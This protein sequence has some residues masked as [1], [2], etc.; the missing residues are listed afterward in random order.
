M[1]DII[2]LITGLKRLHRALFSLLAF[3]KHL[4][5]ISPSLISKGAATILQSIL[6]VI[7]VLLLSV[8]ST[9]TTPKAEAISTKIDTK[10]QLVFSTK[11]QNPVQI[12]PTIGTFDTDILVP[13]KKSQAIKAARD[14]EIEKARV[15]A[16]KQ[17]QIAEQAKAQPVA[18]KPVL[19]PS[20]GSVWDHLAQCESGGRWNANT[21]NGYYGGLQFDIGTFGGRADLATREQQ[22]AKAEQI[23]AR[24]GFA[25][26][27]ACAR[28]LGL[29]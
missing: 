25:P 2:K 26:W 1:F 5:I 10:Y 8:T 9:S 6:L 22:I 12:K 16:V 11:G 17:A 20:D 21:G 15:E 19:L 28:K 24:R 3:T 23:R 13:L 27:P 14:A 18:E 7:P 29:L 4:C